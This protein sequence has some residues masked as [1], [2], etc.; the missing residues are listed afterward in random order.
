MFFDFNLSMRLFHL[1][2]YSII[3][4]MGLMSSSCKEDKILFAGG[5]TE[6]SEKGLSLFEFNEKNGSLKLVSQW[7]AGSNPSFFC[8]SHE[9]NMLYSINEVM[10]FN[11]KPGGGVTAL[12][13]NPEGKSLQKKGELVIP[14]GGPCHI[15][16]SADGGYLFMANYATGSVAVVKLDENGIPLMVSD[17]ILYETTAP[18]VSHA[19]MISQDPSGRH[20]YVTDLGLDR[21][22]IYDL[23]PARGKL[24]P[25][26]INSV[27][28]SKGSGPRHFAFNEDNS[29]FYLINELGSS[30]MVFDVD[31]GE[32]LKLIQ[33]IPTLKEDFKGKNYCADIH[34]GANGDFLYGSNRGENS[35]VVFKIE[36][37]GL[38][39]PAGRISCGGD[40]PRNFVI[41]PSG[42]FLLAG[43][44]RSDNISVFRINDETG[45]P[46]G[47]VKVISMKAPGCLRFWN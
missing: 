29:K 5:F 37:N 14:F 30:I 9:R 22:M 38:L 23:D 46:E 21:I 41:D 16:L 18:D 36:K 32:G 17:T 20:V 35:I 1:V 25:Y 15:S 3:I 24:I 10:E 11:G 4:S 42:K 7:D 33:T 2:L 47:P 39:T 28:V 43:N 6:G 19:H 44:Q 8:F 26:K 45:I 31:E 27:P 12:K 13:Y 40:W 34:L